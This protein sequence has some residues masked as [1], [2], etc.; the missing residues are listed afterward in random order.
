MAK[1]TDHIFLV[2]MNTKHES[3]IVPSN[4]GHLCHIAQP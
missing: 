1:K 3:K 2:Y 4:K